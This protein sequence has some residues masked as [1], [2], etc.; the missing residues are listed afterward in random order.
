MMQLNPSLRRVQLI[1]SSSLWAQNLKLSRITIELETYHLLGKLRTGQPYWYY[2]EIIIILLNSLTLTR[3][4]PLGHNNPSFDRLGH[5]KIV[6]QWFMQPGHFCKEIEKEQTK[7]PD[8][9]LF[10][11]SKSYSMDDCYVKKM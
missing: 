10:H 4:I 7:H 3:R 9:Y 8:I 1:T 6:H 2:A 11:L 5:Q